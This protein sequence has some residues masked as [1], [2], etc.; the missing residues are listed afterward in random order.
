MFLRTLDYINIKKVEKNT[1]II[2]VETDKLTTLYTLYGAW[3]APRSAEAIAEDI[4]K[5][6]VFNRQNESHP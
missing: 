6:R 5:M 3:K 4:Q 2:D 1:S